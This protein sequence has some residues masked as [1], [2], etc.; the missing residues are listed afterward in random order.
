[1]PACLLPPADID[2]PTPARGLYQCQHAMVI[3]LMDEKSEEEIV[4]I[5]QYLFRLWLD[6]NISNTVLKSTIEILFYVTGLLGKDSARGDILKG[7]I[8]SSNMFRLITKIIPSKRILD[9]FL[10]DFFNT[11][12]Y[13]RYRRGKETFLTGRLFTLHRSF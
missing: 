3:M 12:L 9:F 11:I 6:H 10:I 5:T 13:H 8:S 4:H 1:M 7:Y 2:H